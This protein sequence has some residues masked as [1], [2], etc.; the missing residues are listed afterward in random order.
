[1]FKSH[2]L[3]IT[4]YFLFIKRESSLKDK[5]KIETI[6]LAVKMSYL[7]I[8]DTHTYIYTHVEQ[9]SICIEGKLERKITSL[10]KVNININF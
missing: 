1:M 4:L 6:S 2:C 9:G 3:T 7:Y 5:I 8:I 10:V